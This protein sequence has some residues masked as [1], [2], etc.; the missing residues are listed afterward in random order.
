MPRPDRRRDLLQLASRGA[1]VVAVAR[2]KDRL[3]EVV[4][5]CRD[6]VAHPADVGERDAC[7]EVVFTTERF[8]VDILVNNAGISSHRNAA[9]IPAEIERMMRVNFFGPVWLTTTALP[10]MLE[11][12]SGRWS[13]SRRWPPPSPTRVSRT[14]GHPRRP[15]PAGPTGW[16][17][18]CTTPV[19]TSRRSPGPIDTEIWRISTRSSYTRPQVPPEVVSS[20]V[21]DV[22]QDDLVKVT[23][24]RQYGAVGALYPLLEAVALGL[25]RLRGPSAQPLGPVVLRLPR[26]VAEDLLHPLVDLGV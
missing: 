8:A 13:T 14:T 9:R 24:P 5:A 26:V 1:T 2:R 23:V 19:S 10:G 18:T 20:A 16:P 11:R 22:I 17:S 7:E 25:R 4:A 3:D 15:S 21:V 6:A 12:G